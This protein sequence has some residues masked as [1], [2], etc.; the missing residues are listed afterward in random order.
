VRKARKSIVTVI[1]YDRSGVKRS[2]S[3]FIVDNE[4]RIITNASVMKNAYAAEVFSESAHYKKVM[5]LNSNKGTDL[6]L[7]QINAVNEVPIGIDYEYKT[8]PGDRII[9]LGKPSGF[10][11]TVS[12]GLR[13]YMLWD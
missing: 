13:M 12:E 4:G 2:G 6:A 1:T 5:L 10:H 3:G 8:R 7:L 9:V 11:I